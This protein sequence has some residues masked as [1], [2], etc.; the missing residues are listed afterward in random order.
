MLTSSIKRNSRNLKLD[1]KLLID[2]QELNSNG[3]RFCE[4]FS[5][6]FCSRN[7]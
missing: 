3:D 2:A 7:F 4:Q 5:R 1:F 6:D